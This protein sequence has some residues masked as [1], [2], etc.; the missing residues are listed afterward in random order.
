[1]LQWWR[2]MEYWHKPNQLNETHAKMC[3]EVHV[4][5]STQSFHTCKILHHQL[6]HCDHNVRIHDAFSQSTAKINQKLR[7][8]KENDYCARQHIFQWWTWPDKLLT[9]QLH[10]LN[11]CNGV[12]QLL[13][14]ADIAATDHVS[15]AIRY[16]R[17]SWVVQ[18]LW[19]EHIVTIPPGKLG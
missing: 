1:M 5:R 6:W 19:R 14:F 16:W 3:I 2:R 12:F 8:L 11:S 17:K 13:I 4:L 10:A 9:A 15:S 7:P 18:A